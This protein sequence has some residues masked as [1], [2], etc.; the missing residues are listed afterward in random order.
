MANALH[1]L[2]THRSEYERLQ[3]TIDEVFPEGDSTFDYE[4]IRNV[5]FLEGVI[6]ETLR[7]KPAVPSGQPRVTPAAGL[8]IDEFWIPGDVNVI[9]PQFVIQRDERYFHRASEFIPERWVVDG[10]MGSYDRKN[11][12]Y[13]PF[14]IGESF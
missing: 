5:P 6:N 14:Q 10:E 11:D 2:V 1:F 8:Q 12:A 7:L 9:V 13:F 4:K 3:S